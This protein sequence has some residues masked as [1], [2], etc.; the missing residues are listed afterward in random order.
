MQLFLLYEVLTDLRYQNL[1]EKRLRSFRP[2]HTGISVIPAW[3]KAGK[4]VWGSRWIRYARGVWGSGSRGAPPLGWYHRQVT[5]HKIC[6]L[7]KHWT[8]PHLARAYRAALLP[9]HPLH[10]HKLSAWPCWHGAEHHVTFFTHTNA[11][12]GIVGTGGHR[13]TSAT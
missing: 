3:V 8:Q 1:E 7:A 9:R 13:H 10:P 5:L 4:W 6:S 11:A 12:H 2:M